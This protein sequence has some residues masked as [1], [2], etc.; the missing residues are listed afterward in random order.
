M[1]SAIRLDDL[2]SEF[3][4]STVWTIRTSGGI[5]YPGFKHFHRQSAILPQAAVSREC[6]ALP[7]FAKLE[8]RRCLSGEKCASIHIFALYVFA[9]RLRFWFECSQVG[10]LS[11]HSRGRHVPGFRK[12]SLFWFTTGIM[13]VVDWGDC[14]SVTGG[15]G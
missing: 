13:N 14:I 10:A 5:E 8:A 11:N 1:H 15:I 3:R 12:G 7:R 4:M 9:S 6:G 2:H